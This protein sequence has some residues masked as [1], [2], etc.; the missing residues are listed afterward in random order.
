MQNMATQHPPPMRYM[1]WP[2]PTN[3]TVRQTT[4]ER[5]LDICRALLAAFSIKTLLSL[6]QDR[7]RHS[8]DVKELAQQYIAERG[9][10]IA[11]LQSIRDQ[12]RHVA[13]NCSGDSRADCPIVDE[14][15]KPYACN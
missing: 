2:G 3:G 1:Q 7:S 11:K 8:A 4:P 14:L 13:N 10:D 5:M 9:E 12:L 15:A 6:W